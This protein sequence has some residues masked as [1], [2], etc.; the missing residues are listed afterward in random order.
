[1]KKHLLI[2]LGAWVFSF[3]PLLGQN[4]EQFQEMRQRNLDAASLA[5]RSPV[6]WLSGHVKQVYKVSFSPD[7]NRL[8]SSGNDGMLWLW[9]AW[10]G[11]AL[12]SLGFHSGTSRFAFSSTGESILVEDSGART[13][14]LRDGRKTK[15][16]ARFGKGDVQ[17]RWA[18]SP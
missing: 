3:W 10:T 12:G 8:A 17:A 7:G 18:A 5:A 16:L 14:E 4:E 2:S 11:E 13:V 1:M 6:R 9:D 15:L